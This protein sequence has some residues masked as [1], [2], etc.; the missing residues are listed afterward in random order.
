V[1]AYNNAAYHM[2]LAGDIQ[3]A[4][5]LLD[6]GLALV[7]RHGLRVPL[8]WL[9][10]TGGELALVEHSWDAAQEW[11]ERGL[12][13]AVQQRNQSQIASYHANLKRVALGRGAAR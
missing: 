2:V 11:F 6:M 9:Y 12:A 13:E 10:S 8:Q 4:R 7:E 3:G 5:Q 1:L